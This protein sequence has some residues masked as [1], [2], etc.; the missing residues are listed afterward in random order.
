MALQVAGSLWLKEYFGLTYYRITHRSYIGTRDKIEMALDGSTEQTYGPKYA[1]KSDT[2]TG[3]IEFMLKYDDLNLD[4]LAAVY[5][6]MEEQELLN[7]ISESPNGRYS[8]RIGYLYEWLTSKKLNLIHEASGN[9]TDLLDTDRY[10]TGNIIKNARWRINDNLLGVPEFCPI[11][12]KTQ[13]L[14]A[15]LAKDIRSEIEGL[16]NNYTPEIFQRATQYLYRKETRSS[17]EIESEKP[18]PDR[19]DRF[20]NLLHHAGKQPFEDVMAEQNLTTLQNAIVDPRYAQLGFR[21]FQ[22]YIGQAN[23]RGE[24][25]YHYICPPPA[26]VRSMMKGLT[27]TE[28]KTSRTPAAV[29]AAIIAFGFVFI[30]PFLDGN[31]RIHRFLIHDMLTRDGLAEQG[32]I[33]PVSAHMLQNITEYDTVLEEYSKPLMQRIR[34]TISANGDLTI[35]NTENISPY[36][37]YPDLTLQSE[38]LA[39]TIFATI[40]QDLLEEL[41][42]LERYD[43]LKKELQQ[44]IDMPDRRLRDVIMYLHQNKGIFPN[45]RKKYFE[46]ITDAEFKEMESIYLELFYK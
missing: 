11:I 3:H 26:M 37:R 4:L 16:K 10:L 1:P 22:N 46:E 41:F 40:R 19:V 43:V 42:F 24:E 45:R 17:Y 28:E 5:H 25:I 35:D 8:R 32:L 36:F 34:F 38:Y 2:V 14:D 18:S 44:L 9:Y 33:I 7:Y 12:R 6:K 29:R 13:A 39:N 30:H 21:N 31:G 23:Y 27:I 20:I 15:L